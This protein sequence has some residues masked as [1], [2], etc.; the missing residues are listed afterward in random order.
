MPALP[1]DFADTLARVLEPDSYDE[2]AEIIEAATLLDDAALRRFLRSF[3]DRVRESPA[4]VRGDELRG[5]LHAARS[6]AGR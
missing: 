5:F 3:A 2:A 4:R 1:D 6:P